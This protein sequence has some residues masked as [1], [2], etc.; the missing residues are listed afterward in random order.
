M[1]PVIQYLHSKGNTLVLN[2][3]ASQVGIELKEPF[4]YHATLGTPRIF[5]GSTDDFVI[6]DN[7]NYKYNNEIIF[8]QRRHK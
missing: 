6:L 1:L 8:N 5:T 4:R 2:K 7:D 3:L